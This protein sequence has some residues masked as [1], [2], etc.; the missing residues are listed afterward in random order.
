MAY[1]KEEK[2]ADSGT[3][4]N[5]SACPTWDSYQGEM[6]PFVQLNEDIKRAGF[7]IKF[8]SDKPRK[9]TVN[10]FDNS[11]TDFW[12]DVE[13]EG[14]TRTWTMSQ[15]SL[16][17][18]LQKYKPLSGKSFDIKL[19]PVDDEFKEQFPKYKGKDRY[20]VTP[21][22]GSAAEATETGTTTSAP[23]VEEVTFK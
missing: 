4:D 6:Y 10:K 3:Q 22:D 1:D 14:E 12:F 16:V 19:I 9:E 23:K 7:R 11:A 20:S 2:P 21:V 5:A 15:K 13:Y 17:M 8:L 18:E